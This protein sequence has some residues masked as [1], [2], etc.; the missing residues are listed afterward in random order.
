MYTCNYRLTCTNFFRLFRKLRPTVGY[1]HKNAQCFAIW[2]L[3]YKLLFY[4]IISLLKW[5]TK[6]HVQRAE[7]AEE[8]R[9]T[10]VLQK[11][12]AYGMCTLYN[13][14]LIHRIYIKIFVVT[15]DYAFP[16]QRVSI[17]QCILYSIDMAQ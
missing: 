12:A 4:K 2:L 3:F 1:T 11:A 6:I 9:C 15:C 17:V 14:F 16:P 5:P 7:I 10:C 13:F 8:C